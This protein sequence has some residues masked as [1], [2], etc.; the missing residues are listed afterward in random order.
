MGR[1]RSPRQKQFSFVPQAWLFTRTWEQHGVHSKIHSEI[2]Q[3]LKQKITS[4]T[5]DMLCFADSNSMTE[6]KELKQ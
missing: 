2:C 3:F 1:L 6:M 4:L 5:L